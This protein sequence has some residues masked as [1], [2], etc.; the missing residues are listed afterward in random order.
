MA[1][2]ITRKIGGFR[3]LNSEFRWFV[4]PCVDGSYKA[5]ITTEL[6][7]NWNNYKYE[8][9]SKEDGL[10]VVNSMWETFKL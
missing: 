1:N 9:E 10:K 4:G 8:V 7:K 3:S 2:T 5:I 6:K